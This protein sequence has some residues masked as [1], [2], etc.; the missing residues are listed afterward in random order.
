MK[1]AI[2]DVFSAVIL[3]TFFTFQVSI[4][5]QT[6]SQWLIGRWDG[7]VE[8]LPGKSGPARTFRVHEISN[9]GKILAMWS[10]TGQGATTAD[11]RV[12]NQQVR[13]VVT[14]SKSVVEMA[15]EGKIR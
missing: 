6:G 9:D 3:S 5:Q 2:A 15:R 12:D 13:V 11:V 10:V 14:G 7:S 4:A 8:G 1:I